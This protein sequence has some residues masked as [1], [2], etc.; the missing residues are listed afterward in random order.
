MT[1]DQS[2]PTA[3]ELIKSL[4]A[5]GCLYRKGSRPTYDEAADLFK[6]ADALADLTEKLAGVEAA[7]HEAHEHS[8]RM[9]Y[10][11]NKLLVAVFQARDHLSELFSDEDLTDERLRDWSESDG[12]ALHDDLLDS[13]TGTRNPY[14]NVCEERDAALAREAGLREALEDYGRHVTGCVAGRWSCG[15]PT[16]DGGYRDMYGGNWYGRGELPPCSCGLRA[17]LAGEKP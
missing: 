1:D 9:Q 13:I 5:Q 15:G 14:V 4:R 11:R 6:A 8:I 7:R 12:P 10:S 17:A 16:E 2:K 3:G